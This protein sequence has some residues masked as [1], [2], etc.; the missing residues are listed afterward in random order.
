MTYLKRLVGAKS[1]FKEQI[2]G[3]KH[4]RMV[5]V[6]LGGLMFRTCQGQ[7]S[8]TNALSSNLEIVN[9][10]IFPNHKGIYT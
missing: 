6:I 2:L 10:K 9:L 8:F 1:F 3:D 5:A 7:G 4:M